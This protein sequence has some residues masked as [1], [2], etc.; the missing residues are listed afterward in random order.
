MCGLFKKADKDAKQK[1]SRSSPALM[2]KDDFPDACIDVG[3]KFRDDRIDMLK[4][5]I[6][7]GDINAL[8]ELLSLAEQGNIV[9]QGAL[10][11]IYYHGMGL[12]TNYNEAAKWLAKAAEGGEPWA[13]YA[14]AVSYQNGQ[15]VPKSDTEAFKWMIKSAQDV[16]NPIG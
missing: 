4:T 2:T 1:E 8:N 7:N 11:D 14:L 9:A 6:K 15:G 3:D 13:Q 10:G 12:S 5:R 16:H